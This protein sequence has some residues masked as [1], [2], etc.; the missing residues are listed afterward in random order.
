[1]VKNIDKALR[2]FKTEKKH[3]K[4]RGW[5][6][7]RGSILMTRAANPARPKV[8]RPSGR[9][10]TKEMYPGAFCLPEE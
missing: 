2:N 1:M 6:V 4:Q 9:F 3:P 8:L 7:G 10:A 5:S